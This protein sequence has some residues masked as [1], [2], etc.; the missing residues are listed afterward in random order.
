[1]E[2][3]Q[4][5][6]SPMRLQAIGLDIGDTPG[7]VRFTLDV[8]MLGH[9]LS[10]G[11]H[12]FKAKDLEDVESLMPR[13]VARHLKRREV[14]AQAMAAGGVGWIDDAALAIMNA[15]GVQLPDALTK[16][17]AEVELSFCFGGDDGFQCQGQLHWEDGTIRG[18]V[19]RDDGGAYFQFANNTLRIDARA[20]PSTIIAS[21]VGRRL[22]EVI[23]LNLIPSSAMIVGINEAGR[24]ID[25]HLETGRIPIPS[26]TSHHS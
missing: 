22:G 9:D 11:V 7:T 21:L 4:G 10:F 12:R 5:G 26:S 8:A 15:A 23:D 24:I 6:I 1:M 2:P 16:M 17:G 18:Y 14:L 3:T 19:S 25:I 13:L 20:F